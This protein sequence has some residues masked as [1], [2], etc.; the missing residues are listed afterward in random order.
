MVLLINE[1]IS[2]L[3]GFRQQQWQRWSLVTWQ[4]LY[5]FSLMHILSL[6]PC[7]NS[8][9]KP[10]PQMKISSFLEVS[11]NEG[12][13]PRFEVRP[14]PSK[15]YYFPTTLGYPACYWK[16]IKPMRV[17]YREGRERI[18]GLQHFTFIIGNE[19]LMYWGQ[20]EEDIMILLMLKM[21]L[22]NICMRMTLAN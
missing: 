20:L 19:D 22:F 10:I 7:K 3:W 18:T 1:Q 6:I 15:A 11:C 9:M 21:K 8:I 14:F 2:M 16:S 12:A 17:E 4:E 5:I 13:E